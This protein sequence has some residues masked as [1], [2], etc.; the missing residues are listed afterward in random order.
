M[1]ASQLYSQETRALGSTDDEIVIDLVHDLRQPLGSIEV[2]AYYLEMRLTPEQTDLRE[3]ALKLQDLVEEA[4]RI[5]S[6]AV[7][8]KTM[9][10]V[11]AA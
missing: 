3:Y 5:L 1:I 2:I 11:A 7:D 6:R 9:A 4:N 10:A 8:G